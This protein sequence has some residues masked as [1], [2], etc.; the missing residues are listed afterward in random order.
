MH[1]LDCCSGFGTRAW[2]HAYAAWYDHRDAGHRIRAAMFG[3]L[4]DRLVRWA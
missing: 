2:H 4:A 3:W 1:D